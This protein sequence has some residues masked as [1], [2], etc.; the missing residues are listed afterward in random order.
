[1]TNNWANT[2]PIT[3]STIQTVDERD[4]D[5]MPF[6]TG[7]YNLLDNPDTAKACENWALLIKSAPN[8]YNLYLGYANIHPDRRVLCFFSDLDKNK[9]S[10]EKRF[11]VIRKNSLWPMA[12]FIINK[13]NIKTFEELK[14]L[15]DV[16]MNLQYPELNNLRAT[17]LAGTLLA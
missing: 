15:I 2:S 8:E 13:H 6:Y 4:N 11:C 7:I 12:Q 10:N 1:M 5:L 17:E 16:A 14:K 9:D 3:R